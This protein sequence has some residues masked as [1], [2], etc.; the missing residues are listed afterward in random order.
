MSSKPKLTYFNLQGRGEQVRILFA[1]AGVEFEDN[2]VEFKDWPSIKGSTPFG[3]MPVLEDGDFVLAQGP[4]IVQYVAQK[5]N[6]WPSDPKL[7]ALS[8]SLILAVEDARIIAGP[9]GFIKDEEEKK[10]KLKEVVEKL[11]SQWQKSF[12]KILGD[13]KFFTGDSI[14]AADLV[15]YE[16]ASGLAK[17]IGLKYEE[18]LQGLLDRVANHDKIK[19]HYEKHPITTFI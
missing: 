17:R 12:S 1:F 11:T 13:K 3:S 15:F 10:K 16:T 19:S 6:I 4:A 9:L 8:L 14:S 2:R 7:S 18:N 5:Y